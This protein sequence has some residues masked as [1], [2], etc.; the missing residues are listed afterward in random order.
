MA[1]C[2]GRGSSRLS[3]GTTSLPS[4]H[5][6]SPELCTTSNP[7]WSIC[8]QHCISSSPRLCEEHLQQSVTATSIWLS[9]WR[10][11]VNVEKTVTMAFTRHPFPSKVSITLND[12]ALSTVNEHRHLGLILSSDLRWSAHIDKNF[13]KSRTLA[14]HNHTS[15]AHTL[16]ESPYPLLLSL[17]QTSGGVC[18]H[19][20]AQALSSPT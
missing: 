14:L 5:N 9:N 2:A 15:S 19:S 11:T 6:W 4:L 18:L 3:P 20:M 1:P 8:R 17:H 16:P 12:N 7:V 10:L 13:V